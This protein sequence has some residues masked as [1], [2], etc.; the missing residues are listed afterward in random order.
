MKM[1]N[2]DSAWK[3]EI[4]G[5]IAFTVVLSLPYTVPYLASLLSK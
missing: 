4:L 3:E 5:A 2:L 1:E